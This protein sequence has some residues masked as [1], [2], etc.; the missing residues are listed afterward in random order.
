MACAPPPY[1]SALQVG[2][3]CGNAAGFSPPVRW[4]ADAPVLGLPFPMYVTGYFGSGGI[5]HLY[6]AAGPATPGLNLGLGF[7][8]T[9]YLDPVSV[10]HLLSLTD[11]PIT[12][13]VTLALP[14]APALAGVTVTLQALA[15][16]SAGVPSPAGTIQ[17]SNALQLSL[18]N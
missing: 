11:A 9:S 2:S 7:G 8:C 10:Q 12:S 16:A 1:A 6:W 14:A 18:G 4:T 15:F 3:G 5:V 13:M 17:I